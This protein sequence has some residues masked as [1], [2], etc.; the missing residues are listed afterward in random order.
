MSAHSGEFQR[1][2]D[3]LADVRRAEGGEYTSFSVRGKRFGYYWPR[4]QTVGLKQTLSEQQALVAERPH[5]FEEQFTAGGFGW[6]VVHLAEIEV[7]ELSELVYEAWR[8]S[9]PEELAAQ[10]PFPW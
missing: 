5:V 8:L 6:V 4:T 1:M 2:V 9:A 3:T 10:L 7:D